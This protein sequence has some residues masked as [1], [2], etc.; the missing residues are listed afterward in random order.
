MEAFNKSEVDS[1]TELNKK[2][3]N[4]INTLNSDTENEK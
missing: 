1:T 3:I 2:I 4:I